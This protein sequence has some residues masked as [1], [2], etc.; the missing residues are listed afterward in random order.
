MQKDIVI[1]GAGIVGLAI[2]RKLKLD[3]PKLDITV[4]EK[5]ESIGKHQTGRNSG[6]IHSGIYYKPGSLKATN[7]IRGYTMLLEYCK[8]KNIHYDLCGKIIVATNES[9][10]SQLEEIKRRGE[11]NGLKDLKFLSE[12][13]IKVRE[14]NIK[15]IKGI[16]VPQTGI[17]DFK[18]V[19]ENYAK[20]FIN[21]GG[22]LR[23]QTSV[24]NI[25]KTN[26]ALTIET[27]NGT[28]EAR[29]VIN[30]AGLN[31]DRV[32]RMTSPSVNLRIIPFRGEYYFL[33]EEKKGLINNLVYPVPDPAFPFLGVHFTKTVHGVVEAG[34]NA[35]LSFKRE[36]YTRTSFNL[37]DTIEILNWPGFYQIVKKYWRTGLG[38][39]KRSL[40]KSSFTK[41]LQQLMPSITEDDLV[42]GVAGVRAQAC[43]SN[44]KLLDDFSIIE[45]NLVTHICNA[46][47]PAATSSLSIAETIGDLVSKKLNYVG[48][49]PIQRHN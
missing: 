25:H 33:K 34:P 36:G 10:I 2:A 12:S 39:M 1:V 22:E 29:H 43:D 30:C 14:P 47:S 24:N 42:T 40:S 20:D 46:P 4:L 28:F 32:A 44:G 6:V 13:E 23:F 5:E 26:N 18:E 17:I 49:I 35:V 45:D 41:A 48:N 16:F 3:N 11:A 27:S 37:F 8:Q 31:S 9:E 7:C 19:A 38:E 15:G 21:A